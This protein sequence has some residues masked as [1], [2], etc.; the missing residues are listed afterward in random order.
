MEGWK[1]GRRQEGAASF[2]TSCKSSSSFSSFSTRSQNWLNTVDTWTSTAHAGEK[3]VHHTNWTLSR[4]LTVPATFIA[5][6]EYTQSYLNI[7][8]LFFHYMHKWPRTNLVYPCITIVQTI[9]ENITSLYCYECAWLVANTF[10]H[11]SNSSKC[12]G[13][14]GKALKLRPVYK[15][16][17]TSICNHLPPPLPLTHQ[18]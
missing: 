13:V 4:Q 11:T 3:E 16:Q 9:L 18:C 7:G 15:N 12:M 8:M 1:D 17:Y 14:N 5:H 2:L 10:Y 6:V